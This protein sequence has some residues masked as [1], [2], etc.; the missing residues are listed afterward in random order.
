MKEPDAFWC[1]VVKSIH[2]VDLHQWHTSGKFGRVY[3]AH[4]LIFKRFRTVSNLLQS[5]R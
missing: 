3:G 4:G 2:G 5:S 1:K